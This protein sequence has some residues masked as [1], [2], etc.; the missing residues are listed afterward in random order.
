MGN[1]QT[2]F[3]LDRT[4]PR[5][6]V[7]M[8]V[9]NGASS[10]PETMA[11]IFAQTETGFE[12]IVVDDGSTDETAAILARCNDPRLR[13]LRQDNQGLTRALM[14]GCNHANAS[15]IA[16]HDCGD[17][18]MPDRF[19]RQMSLFSDPEV[20]LASC[21]VR[22][23]GP[24]RELL[25]DVEAA[26]D[27]IRKSLLS[28]PLERIEGLPHH[29]SAMFRKSAYVACGGYRAEFRYAQDLDLWIR[30]ASLGRIAVV[31]EVL[32]VSRFAVNS[33][34]SSRRDEQLALT[35]IALRLRD[36]AD[37]T[38]LQDATRISSSPPAPDRR[39]RARA[40]YFVS[41]CLRARGDSRYKPYAREALRLNPLS[42]RNWAL[43]LRGLAP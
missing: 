23:E 32:Y 14:N 17:V 19:S 28:D 24:G 43:F 12:L 11:S 5:L 42:L 35:R 8:A 1:S 34:S 25:Y 20:V 10:L 31:P 36:G 13:I 9:H 22:H 4:G 40:L 21:F 27:R 29:G 26:G 41:Q 2:V 18:S 33:I 39:T 15:L 30:L 16:R 7:V 38:L 3:R 37:S 6:S